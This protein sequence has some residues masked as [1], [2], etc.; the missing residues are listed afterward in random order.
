MKKL[1]AI[2]I[3]ATGATGQELVRLL[4]NDSNYRHLS[5]FVREKIDLKHNKLTVHKIDFSKLN[6]IENLVVGD[7]L[8]SALGTTKKKAGDKNKQFLVD[9]TYQFEFAN[10]ASENG[11]KYYSLV[12]SIGAD[13]KSFFFY[14]KIKGQLEEAVKNLSFKKIQIFQPPSLI[15][16]SE[17]MRAGEKTSLKF[18]NIINR[19]GLLKSLKPIHV[20]YL[21]KKMIAEAQLKQLNRITIYKPKDIRI[22]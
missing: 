13:E 17:L 8:F 9:F 18:L 1:N 6:D 22:I 15:R 14:P 11:V 19:L 21:A 2:V 12:S 16:Q 7:I 10:M 4:L 5:V 3:G 20:N